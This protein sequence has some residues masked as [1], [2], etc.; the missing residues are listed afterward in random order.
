MIVV[1][2]SVVIVGI[3]VALVVVVVIRGHRGSDEPAGVRRYVRIRLLFELKIQIR[4]NAE[5]YIR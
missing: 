2:L 5:V 1:C 3:G 4:I